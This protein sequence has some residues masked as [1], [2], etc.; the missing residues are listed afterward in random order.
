MVVKKGFVSGFGF[1]IRLELNI[2]IDAVGMIGFLIL[3]TLKI[4]FLY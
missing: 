1:L 3:R 2:I 4:G